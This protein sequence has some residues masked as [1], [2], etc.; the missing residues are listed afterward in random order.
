M[1]R[2]TS[3]FWHIRETPAIFMPILLK[4]IAFRLRLHSASCTYL[5]DETPNPTS[6][7]PPEIDCRHDSDPLDINDGATAVFAGICAPAFGPVLLVVR[8]LLFDPI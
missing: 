8:L 5:P 3:A 2:H 1:A 7:R 4:V 6:C